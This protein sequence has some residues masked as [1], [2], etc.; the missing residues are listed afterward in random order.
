MLKNIFKGTLGV[1]LLTSPCYMYK[2]KK[3]FSA[4]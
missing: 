1:G 3:K 2:K 4:E